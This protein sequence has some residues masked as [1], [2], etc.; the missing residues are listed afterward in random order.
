MQRRITHSSASVLSP[1]RFAAML[2]LLHFWSAFASTEDF[3]GKVVGVS[4]GNT[5]T[6]HA[7]RGVEN[8]SD[9]IA[10]THQSEGI[11]SAIEPSSSFLS[12]AT[13]RKLES[14]SK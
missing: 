8:A 5:I 11:P 6:G 1:T 2:L 3:K 10:L 12:F 13:T 9:C 14:R 4:D 7:P